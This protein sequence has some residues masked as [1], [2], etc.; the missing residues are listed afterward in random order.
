MA[1]NRMFLTNGKEKIFIAKYYPGTG[2]YT[3]NENLI[4]KLDEAFN[5]DDFGGSWEE[6]MRS[7]YGM[8]GHAGWKIVY[9]IER[10]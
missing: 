4:L 7:K 9:E 2:W 8:C 3:A 1:N 5:K 6:G 10:E